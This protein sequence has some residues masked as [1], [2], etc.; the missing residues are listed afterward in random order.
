M[1]EALLV[2]GLLGLFLVFE[3]THEHI[4]SSETDLTVSFSIRVVDTE[5]ETG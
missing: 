4:S 3:V 5:L 1:H 2:Y